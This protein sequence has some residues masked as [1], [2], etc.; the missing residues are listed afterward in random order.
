MIQTCS[1]CLLDTTVSSI[2]FDEKG[3][4]NYCKCHDEMLRCYPQD[5]AE[6]SARFQR[7][8]EQIRKAGKG[9]RYDCI[10]GVSGGTDSTYT[11][12]MAKKHGLRPLAV[13]FDNGWSSETSIKNIKYSTGKLGVDLYTYVVNW[14]EF[15]HIQTAFLKA[16][17]PCVDIPTDIGISGTLFRLAA[18]EGLK[19]ILSGMSFI[20]EGTVPR[21][22]SFIDGTY[23]K[24]VNGRFG[25]MPLKSFPNLT[26]YK[27]AY[28]TFIKNIKMVPF[29]NYFHYD[30]LEAR[31]VLEK[32]L[33]WK[34]YGGHHYENI[35]SQWAFGWY[36]VRKF[37]F[38][39]RKVSLS[40]PV[41]MG[42]LSREAALKEIAEP[43]PVKDGTTDYIIKKLG[44]SV[45]EFDT[46][47]KAPNKSFLD[48][49]TSYPMLRRFKFLV[50]MAVDMNLI[51]PVVYYKYFG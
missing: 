17:V 28:Y 14:E 38:D 13:H 9:R 46:I 8:I 32:E 26:V 34:Y 49:H 1:R 36:T 47:M 20:T 51:S 39:K 27:G 19:H 23:V 50:R 16:S 7:L 29:T 44:L 35:Y 2:K 48:Y 22:W 41:R 45:E 33:G 12:Y 10:V 4:C 43:P 40:G 21:E 24:D 3:V 25:G 42:R 37:G 18:E 6:R 31:G 15:K 30:K 5:E 11:L